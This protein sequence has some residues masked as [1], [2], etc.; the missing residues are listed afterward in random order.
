[1]IPGPARFDLPEGL[2]YLDGNSLGALPHG[3]ADRMSEVVRTEWL[4]V[5]RC[6]RHHDRRMMKG[7][8]PRLAFDS[9]TRP[10][11]S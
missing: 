6:S 5:Q 9:S 8:S 2:V 7:N 1:M 11:T 4:D 3:V 10:G